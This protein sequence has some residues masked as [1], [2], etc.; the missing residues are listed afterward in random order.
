[1]S[2]WKPHQGARLPLHGL[3]NEQK[4]NPACAGGAKTLKQEN[5]MNLKNHNN[6]IT[7]KR[8]TLHKFLNKNYNGANDFS[9]LKSIDFGLSTRDRLKNLHQSNSDSLQEAVNE[10]TKN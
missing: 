3:R 9:I 10:R 8:R 1:M 6:T 2:G 5:C 7:K 4:K